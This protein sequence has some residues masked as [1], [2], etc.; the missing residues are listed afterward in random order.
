MASTRAMLSD[1]Y[2]GDALSRASSILMSVFT[3]AP[4]IAPLIGAWV[5]EAL[6]WRWV[7]WTLGL[8]AITSALLIQTLPKTLPHK[9]HKPYHPHSI[10]TKY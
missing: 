8:V 4:V 7:F 6:G 9:Q 5:L 1:L 2:K 10:I 3:I